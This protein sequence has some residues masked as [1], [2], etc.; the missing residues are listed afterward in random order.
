MP[1]IALLILLIPVLSLALVL[2]L[3]DPPP[4]AHVPAGPTGVGWLDSWIYRIRIWHVLASLVLTGLLF[5]AMGS[6]DPEPFFVLAML[7]VLALGIRT[8]KNEVVTLMSTPDDAFPGRNDKLTWLVL[9]VL[10][11]PLGIA[12]FR[13]Y[14][15]ARWPER[16]VAAAASYA[17]AAAKPDPFPEGP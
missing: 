9:L 7:V 10:V 16:I 6:R 14:R 12:A 11:P 2:K 13:T 4:P 1:A 17:H 5:A 15:R 8:W 3:D